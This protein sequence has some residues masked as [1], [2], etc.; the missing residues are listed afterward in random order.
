[1]GFLSSICHLEK[2]DNANTGEKPLQIFCGNLF[3]PI[4]QSGTVEILFNDMLISS[5]C[6]SLEVQSVTHAHINHLNND[7]KASCLKF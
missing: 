6:L 5:I 3:F 2:N 1:M 7:E 4:K